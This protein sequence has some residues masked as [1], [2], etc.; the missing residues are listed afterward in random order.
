MFTISAVPRKVRSP[1]RWLWYTRRTLS[2][3]ASLGRFMTAARASCTGRACCL[4]L[5]TS[6]GMRLSSLLL[7]VRDPGNTDCILAVNRQ[8]C[9]R[10]SAALSAIP[11]RHGCRG[12]RCS[13]ASLARPE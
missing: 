5:R 9:G 2:V 8:L 4:I 7:M 10:C 12:A 1:L 13:C 6:A 3:A 11:T